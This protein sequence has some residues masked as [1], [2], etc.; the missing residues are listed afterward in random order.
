MTATVIT[1][2][3]G[4]SYL[5]C[6]CERTQVRRRTRANGAR[7]FVIQC[8]DCGR[9][10][11]AV[12]QRSPEVLALAEIIDFDESLRDRWNDECR[13]HRE[14]QQYIREYE[15]AQK[16]AEWWAWYNAYLL[17]PSWREKRLKVLTRAGGICE[18]CRERKATQ[19]HHKSYE[20]VGNELLFELVAI[21][22]DCHRILHPDMDDR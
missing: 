1:T 12:G 2:Q 5:Q 13:A 18:G 20:H 15:Q 17:T 7:A 3:Y 22:D 19:V 21:C 10:I 4:T 14:R 11:R 6:D 8:L 16:S 9:E